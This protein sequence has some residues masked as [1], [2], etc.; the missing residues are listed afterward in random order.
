MYAFENL[1]YFVLQKFGVDPDTVQIVRD[2]IELV[3]LNRSLTHQEFEKHI[4]FNE[5]GL[6]FVDENG[7]W[8]KGFVYI[9]KG[10]NNSRY[11]NTET[12][13]ITKSKVPKFHIKQCSTIKNMKNKSKFD[14]KYVF[15]NTPVKMED[16][17]GIYKDLLLC[18]NCYAQEQ[19]KN[20]NIKLEMNT[21]EYFKKIILNKQDGVGKF[22][23]SDLPKEGPNIPTDEN[24][25]TLNWSELSKIVR[26]LRSFTCEEC[27]INLNT[28]KYYLEVHHI[29]GNKINNSIINLKV[30]CVRCHSEVD[31]LHK[32]NYSRNLKLAEFN[33]KYKQ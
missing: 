17:D 6:F 26:E 3:E 5:D 18:K 16:H 33:S 21:N 19:N 31:E 2:D 12:G 30:L 15:R 24:G 32:R 9:E 20:E 22:H 4:K 13:V 7:K 28:D 25:Y 1:R 10:Y 23:K 8:Q 14:G 11:N 27:K 29:D